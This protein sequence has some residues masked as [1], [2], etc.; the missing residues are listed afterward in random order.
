MK[1]H[2][3][4]TQ[5]FEDI[6]CFRKTAD[7]R[8][9]DRDFRA[10]DVIH[11]REYNPYLKDYDGYAQYNNK[12]GSFPMQGRECLAKIT[13]IVSSKNPCVESKG[14]LTDNYVILSIRVQVLAN[15]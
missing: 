12:G 8:I 14:A 4:K 3:L 13:H 6:F 1:V 9:N 5:Y 7:L 15:A 2:E 11:Y 10:G